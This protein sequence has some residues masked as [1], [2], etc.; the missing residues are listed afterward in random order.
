V[1]N[2][3]IEIEAQSSP[4]ITP[5]SQSQKSDHSILLAAKGG[6]VVFAGSL[7]A[8]GVRFLIGILMARYLGAEQFGLYNLTLSTVTIAVGLAGLG[9]DPALVRYVSVFLKRRDTAR[10][11]GT[12]QVGLGL[13]MIT[14]I[15][16]GIGLYIL[17]PFIVDE[18]FKDPR[19]VPLLR[20]GSLIIPITILGSMLAA[21]TQ[22]F[23]KMHFTSIAQ[24]ITEP[25]VKLILLV[26]VAITIGLNSAS[27][28]MVYILCLV[29]VAAILLYFL[30]RLFDLRRPL[31]SAK[32]NARQMLGFSIPIYGTRL[33]KTFRGNIQTILLGSFQA[34]SSVGVFTVAARVNTVGEMFHSSIVT[35]SAPIV[36]GLYDQG[37]K[38]QLTRFYQ[39]T[40]KWTFSVN[41]PLFLILQLFPGALL[42][43]FGKEYVGGALALSILAWGSLVDAGTGI[44]GVII[45]MTG[46]T[47]LKLVNVILAFIFSVGLNFLLIPHWGL[48]GAAVASTSAN[49]IV[50]LLR[51]SEVYILYRLLP[52]NAG[53]L[54]PVVAGLLALTSAWVINRLFPMETS[55]IYIGFMI[56]LILAVYTG[57]IL[58]MGLSEEDRV[59][60]DRVGGRLRR[61]FNKK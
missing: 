6:S 39:T 60:L 36:S 4:D 48:I 17:A 43:I 42:S 19:L 16:F 24:D 11:W 54:K 44:C 23:S 56:V 59:I 33:I 32:R 2:R 37:E 26:V 13:T 53:F 10:I 38:E 61:K 35:T 31:N 30:N 7:F 50:N 21:T 46:R 58:L 1:V 47:G 45:D 15:I 5:S 28:L 52:Y 8:Y 51:L 57:V 49:I 18:L 9:L 41:L 12:I 3:E 25:I 14:S 34:V 55:L 29:V 40:T 27:A 20:L 22:G